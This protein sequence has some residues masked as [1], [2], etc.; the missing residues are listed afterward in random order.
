MKSTDNTF[1]SAVIA[2]FGIS[3]N[4]IQKCKKET[5]EIPGRGEGICTSTREFLVPFT[6]VPV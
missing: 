2:N 6:I 1:E 5:K 3:S 4:G